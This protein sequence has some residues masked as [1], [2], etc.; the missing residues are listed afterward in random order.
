MKWH[1]THHSCNNKL[2]NLSVSDLQ[3]LTNNIHFPKERPLWKKIDYNH[4]LKVRLAV[5]RFKRKT[6]LLIGWVS[7]K[8]IVHWAGPGPSSSA[9]F[10]LKWAGNTFNS[11]RC[12]VLAPR[13]SLQDLH[14]HRG[15]NHKWSNKI[16]F[17]KHISPKSHCSPRLCV[18]N[19]LIQATGHLNQDPL[20]R[21]V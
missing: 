2:P 19:D 20:L 4:D 13:I 5:E 1:L 17:F 12:W 11:L 9:H 7:P 6:N 14:I 3:S 16:H 10:H 15:C 8:K 18:L 21:V